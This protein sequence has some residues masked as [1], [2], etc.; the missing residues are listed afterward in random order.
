M[1]KKCP[2]CGVPMEGNTCKYCGYTEGSDPSVNPG[3]AKPKKKFYKKWWFWV[4]IILVIGFAV[5][6]SRT[7]DKS[8]KANEDTKQEKT[9]DVA[10]ET[11]E[12]EEPEEPVEPKKE[13]VAKD[14]SDATIES[15]ETYG[16]YLTMYK[17]II[18]EYYANYENAIKGT[19]L[20]DEATFQQLKDETDKSFAQQEEE[21]GDMKDQS[22]VGKDSLVDYLKNYRD[23]LKKTVDTMKQSLQSVQ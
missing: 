9:V 3:G 7:S 1:E 11:E 2:K 12:P 4:L 20:Y 15:I 8:E 17:K 5:G 21:Y 14:T 18:D 23:S 13:F 10:T 22:I 19:V 16:D 6:R